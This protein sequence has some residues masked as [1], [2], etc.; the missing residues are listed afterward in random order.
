MCNG[1][2]Q[3][4]DGGELLVLH[5][6]LLGKPPLGHIYAQANNARCTPIRLPKR[7]IE[8]IDIAI[9]RRLAFVPEKRDASG[10]LYVRFAAFIDLGEQS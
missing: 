1:T 5:K 8:V 10:L 3:P 4:T 6:S 2:G 9:L 7:L